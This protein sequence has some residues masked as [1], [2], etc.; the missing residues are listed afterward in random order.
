MVPKIF[1]TLSTWNHAR[2]EV[3]DYHD[4]EKETTSSGIKMSFC[5]WFMSMQN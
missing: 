1:I 4:Q 5:I 2:K 3:I